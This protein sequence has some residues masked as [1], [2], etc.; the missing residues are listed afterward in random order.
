M[1]K[2]GRRTLVIGG[3][4]LSL[5]ALSGFAGAEEPPLPSLHEGYKGGEYKFKGS[6]ETK[7][8][9]FSSVH[10]FTGET[11]NKSFKCQWQNDMGFF[12][13]GGTVTIDENGG[14]MTMDGVDDVIAKD[15]EMAIA[16]ATGVSA[17]S[18][19]LMYSLWKGDLEAVFPA[20]NVEVKEV[21]G[22]MVV[23]GK[24]L[25]GE[26]DLTIKD[27]ILLSV[28]NEFDP[29]QAEDSKDMEEISDKDLG[30]VLEAMGKPV[31]EDEIAA[32]RRMMKDAGAAIA[33]HKEKI[34]SKTQVTLTEFP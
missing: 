4:A 11:T 6:V 17:G 1:S 18:V 12:K 31:N 30:K 27:G 21:E 34:I 15:P 3:T 23:S 13:H 14:I 25:A 28:V 19:H 26:I 5:V 24:G 8:G 32:M 10:T 9:G 2:A 7:S 29:G 16:S 33:G 20:E 22:E